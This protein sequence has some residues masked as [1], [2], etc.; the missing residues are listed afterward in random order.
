MEY[1]MNVLRLKKKESK[2]KPQNMRSWYD[3]NHNCR[4]KHRHEAPDQPSTDE[5]IS[6][7]VSSY[8]S[9]DDFRKLK[10]F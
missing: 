8:N 2:K 3:K 9:S 5:P 6:H 1:I 4:D 10:N 7:I